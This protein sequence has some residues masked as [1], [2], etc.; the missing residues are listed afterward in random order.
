[1]KNLNLAGLKLSKEES[2]DTI[3]FLTRKRNIEDYKSK[4]NNDLSQAIKEI[5]KQQKINS[6]NEE[7]N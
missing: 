5:N 4:S 3:E 6:K 7:K 2:R 1:M